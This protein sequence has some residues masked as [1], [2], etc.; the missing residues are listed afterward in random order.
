MKLIALTGKAG[1]GKDSVADILCKDHG[2]VRYAFAKPLKDMLRVI[3]VE[4][5]ADRELKEQPHP[6]FGA[7]PRK[8]AQTLGT[9]WM[10][11]MVNKNGWLLLADQHIKSIQH[12]IDQKNGPR[13]DDR[14]L[15]SA[16]AGLVITDCRFPN[17]AAFIAER[18]GVIWHIERPECPAVAAHSSESGLAKEPGD[19]VIVNDGTLDD[20]A[21]EVRLAIE[22]PTFFMVGWPDLEES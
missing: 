6:I 4:L 20:L 11:E 1:A 5:D 21:D 9:E 17:E 15:P 16:P 19:L 14:D 3:G 13:K 12:W 18:D 10:R 22:S 7:S 2:F 8:M